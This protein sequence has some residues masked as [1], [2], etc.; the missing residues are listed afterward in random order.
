MGEIIQAI[1]NNLQNVGIGL[2]LFLLSYISNMA[3]AMY[4]NMKVVGESF[5]KE[6]MKNSLLK[7][8][9]FVIGCATLV[10][11]VST[12]PLF[13]TYT[14]FELPSEFIDTFSTVAIIAVPLYASCKYAL[15][16]FSKMK[17]VLN[18]STNSLAAIQQSFGDTERNE[19]ATTENFIEENINTN[20]GN[21]DSE[22][23]VAMI[24][25][26]AVDYEKMEEAQNEVQKTEENA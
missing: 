17:D 8:L 22:I 24:E 18:S 6:K 23:N 4:Y 3:F 21:E 1:L 26:D 11:V 14:G 5:D 20:V 25:P 12:L 2:L 9:S 15:S 19:E 7:L 10:I 16:A 13:A